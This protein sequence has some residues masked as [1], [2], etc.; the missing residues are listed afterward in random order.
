MIFPD[1]TYM[2]NLL[3]TADRRLPKIWRNSR[4]FRGLRREYAQRFSDVVYT[5]Q[6]FDLNRLQK[7]DLVYHR[8]LIQKPL[9]VFCM[10]PYLGTDVTLRNHIKELM[11]QLQQDGIAVVEVDQ[12]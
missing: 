4:A 11:D 5:E 10:R 8:I 6:I 12:E 1:L 2:E 3:F 9:V 7:Y